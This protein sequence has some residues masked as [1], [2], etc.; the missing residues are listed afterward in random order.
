[1]LGVHTRF[2]SYSPLLRNQNTYQFFQRNPQSRLRKHRVE[3]VLLEMT[4]SITRGT[5]DVR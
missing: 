3:V 2:R 1:V 5:T 4:G